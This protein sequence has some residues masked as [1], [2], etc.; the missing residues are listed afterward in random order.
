[1]LYSSVGRNAF[2]SLQYQFILALRSSKKM[3]NRYSKRGISNTFEH[4]EAAKKPTKKANRPNRIPH[5]RIKTFV[6]HAS[7]L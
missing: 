6:S 5:H 1:V 2:I 4:S 3:G 7:L